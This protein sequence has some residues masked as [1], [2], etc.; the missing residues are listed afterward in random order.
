MQE[1]FR[2]AEGHLEMTRVASNAKNRLGDKP[3][4]SITNIENIQDAIDGNAGTTIVKD[5]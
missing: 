4:A 5:N 2:A 3:R 1:R